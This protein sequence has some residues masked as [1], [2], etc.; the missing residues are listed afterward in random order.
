MPVPKRKLSYG[1]KRRKLQ[2][3]K[4][5]RP[6]TVKCRHCGAQKIAHRLCLDCGKY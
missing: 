2:H 1:R 6:Q 3:K 5:R 4:P